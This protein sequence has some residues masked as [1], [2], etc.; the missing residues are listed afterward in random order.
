MPLDGLPP[1]R[2]AALLRGP[3]G[4]A[5]EVSLAPRGPAAAAGAPP[6]NLLLERRSLPQPA[7]REARLPLDAAAPAAGAAAGVGVGGSDSV[8]GAGGGGGEVAYLRINYFSSDTTPA[9]ARALRA[10]EADGV[11]G[12]VIDLRNNPGAARRVLDQGAVLGALLIREPPAC[13]AGQT[14]RNP[15]P[16][17]PHPLSPTPSPLHP[18]PQ[19]ASSRR[20]SAARRCSSP[21]AR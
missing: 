11:A 1:E 21:T 6:T 19:A 17:L 18:P 13:S 8:G 7:V 4:S 5:V 14:R 15:Q 2:V 20:P 16:S 10:G 3:E 9:L 12:F